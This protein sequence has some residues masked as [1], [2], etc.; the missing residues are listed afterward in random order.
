MVAHLTVED[1]ERRLY[2]DVWQGVREYGTHAPGEVYAPLFLD[3]A[4]PSLSDSILDAGCGSGKGA[5]ALKA[6]GF[7]DVRLCDLTASGL[8]PDAY[9]LPFRPACLWRPLRPQLWYRFGGRFDWVYCCDVLE[10][11]PTPF[12]MLVIHQLLEVT[13]YGLFLSISLVPDSFGAWVGQPLHQTVQNFVQW[14]EQLNAVGKVKECRDLL[15]AGLYLV[16]PR[17]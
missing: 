16:E 9:D 4:R 6:A 7:S 10:H 14:R 1:R 8:V 12:T 11:I 2:E 5:L 15:N 17:C 13:R 3:M